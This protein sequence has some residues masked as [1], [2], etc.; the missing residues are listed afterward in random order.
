MYQYNMM[1]T[2]GT[3][4]SQA[5]DTKYAGIAM[6]LRQRVQSMR[7]G[8]KLQSVRR[9]MKEFEASQATIYSALDLLKQEGVVVHQKGRGIRVPIEDDQAISTV[10]LMV[11][12]R[13]TSPFHQQLIVQLCQQAREHRL[14]FLI[15]SFPSPQKPQEPWPPT[16]V[17]AG[18]LI[19]GRGG[20]TPEFLAHWRGRNMPLVV[21]DRDLREIGVDSVYA[22]NYRGGQLAARHLLSLG[23]R[24][25]GVV[26]HQP[27]STNLARRAQG[28]VDAVEDANLGAR[29]IVLCPK[30]SLAASELGPMIRESIEVHRQ[31]TGLFAM[32]HTSSLATLGSLQEMAVRVPDQMSLVG[33][34]YM[35]SMTHPAMTTVDQSVHDLL[36]ATCRI[37]RARLDRD[38]SPVLHHISRLELAV[39]QSTAP[40]PTDPS[41]RAI[42]A[43][44]D[45]GRLA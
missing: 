33:Y 41:S 44:T 26:L 13:T 5:L 3:L 25:L 39:R 34:D 21:M 32:T 1:T 31:I 12:E 16:E 2:A 8:Q 27:E 38:R 40:P 10:L 22:D 42:A 18:V 24:H 43:I 7:P 23:H 19:P 29:A 36:D 20:V 35:T 6:K 30:R 15:E 11:A 4:N 9:L 17:R 28:F 37:V 14:R 45:Q